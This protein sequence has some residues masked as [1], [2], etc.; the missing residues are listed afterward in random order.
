VTPYW[1]DVAVRVGSNFAGGMVAVVG[2]A[3]ADLLDWRVWAGGALAG[4][5]S[6]LRLLAVAGKGRARK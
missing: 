1:K 2:T 5:L 4:A 6:V 3:G